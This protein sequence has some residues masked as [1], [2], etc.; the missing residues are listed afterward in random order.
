V[1]RV[2]RSDFSLSSFI[3]VIVAFLALFSF[4]AVIVVVA[5]V[6]LSREK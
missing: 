6:L 5:V 1:E 3:V 2:K 4:S